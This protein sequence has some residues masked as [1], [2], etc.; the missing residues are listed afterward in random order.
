MA[1]I[2][3][4]MDERVAEMPLRERVCEIFKK[5]DVTVTAIFLAAGITIRAVVGAITNALK[6]MGNQLANG[7]KQLEQKSLLHFLV[8]LVRSSV[9]FS[10]PLDRQSA[11][12]PST[13]GCLF[14]RRL[15]LFL[16]ST[17]RG[18]VNALP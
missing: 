14:S 17:S 15:F 13:P 12:W 5:Y 8:L 9:S 2:D 4:R 11:I 7:L 16:K 10:K 18:V 1:R 3:T 6:S